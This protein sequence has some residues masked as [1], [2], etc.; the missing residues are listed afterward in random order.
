MKEQYELKET[1]HT[2]GA[3]VC[4]IASVD[5]F[6]DAPAGFHPTDI[7]SDARSV[8]VFGMQSPKTLFEAKSNVPYTFV[9]NKLAERIDNIAMELMIKLE[10]SGS[11]AIPIPSVEPYDYWDAQR[12]HGRGILSLKHAAQLAGLGQLGKN[13]LLINEKFGNRLWLG[14]ILTSGEIEPDP[15][16]SSSGCKSSCSICLEACPQKALNGVT[17]NQQRC[18][19]I[20]Y[21]ST[22][23]GGGI[24]ACNVCRKMCPFARI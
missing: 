16:S 17:V 10:E 19:E 4:G 14:A 5:R 11:K 1:A 22:E 12:R 3:D 24:Y 23:G 9:R 21:T 8:V 2:L 7:M 18:R 13:T 20:V 6:T 15:I